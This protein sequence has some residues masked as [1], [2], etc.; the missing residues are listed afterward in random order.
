MVTI[1][2]KNLFMHQ[3]DDESI[4]IDG[5]CYYCYDS[6][7]KIMDMPVDNNFK[8]DKDYVRHVL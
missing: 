5:N 8:D 1:K 7:D 6:D 2:L 3:S 4:D